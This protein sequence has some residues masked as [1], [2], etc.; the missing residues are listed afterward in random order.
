MCMGMYLCMCMKI[1]SFI[2]TKLK[3]LFLQILFLFL[4]KKNFYKRIS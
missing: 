1:S 2:F 4:Q 3:I